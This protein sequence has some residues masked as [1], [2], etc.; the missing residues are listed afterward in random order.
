M[1]L[2]VN[3][4]RAV[5]A[6][7]GVGRNLEYLFR[8]WSHQPSSFERI[9][10]VSP[11]AIE[12]LPRDPRFQPEVVRSRGPGL[13][14]QSAHLRRKASDADVLF[15]FYSLPPMH[16]GRTVIANLGVY[17]GAYAI[18]GW[19]SRM[20]SRHFAHSARSA[21]AVIVNAPSTARDLV[22]FY[23][24]SPEKMTVIWPGADPRFRPM[25]DQDVAP[26]SRAV[27]AALGERAPYFLFVGKLSRRRLV[28]EILRGFKSVLA[29]HPSYRLVLAG[30]SAPELPLA[31]ELRRLGLA[32]AVR[33]AEHLDQDTLALLYRGAHGFLMPT[34]REG[35]SHPILEAMGSG[36]PVIALKGAVVGALEFV[37]AH[38]EGGSE[39]AVL[40]AEE[41]TP[42]ALAAA[43][44]RLAED[45]DLRARLGAGGVRCAAAFPTWDE[46]AG[47][48]M[49]VLEGVAGR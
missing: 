18:P 21:D 48:V 37:D 17:E 29:D 31:E 10:V 15:G 4:D 38:V 1:I 11:G 19:R 22:D 20:H 32:D 23:R 42:D 12:D 43:M 7:T 44:R 35:F 46:H 39:T 27:E 26:V 9:R 5:G 47:D 33:H 45:G 41:P 16:R 49:R 36:C 40:F 2:A 13:W 8:A 6:R 14:W 3:A 24:V 30:P 25:G 34:T 28:P